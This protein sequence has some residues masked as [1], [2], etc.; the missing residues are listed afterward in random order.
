MDP[1]LIGTPEW[2][3][4][5]DVSHPESQLWLEKFCRDLRTQ[6]FYRNT[7]GPLLPNCFIESLHNW[8]QRRCE[9][10]IDLRINYTPCCEKSKFPYNAS[11]LEQCAVEA[12]A[13]LYSTPSYLWVRN[14]VSAGLK[15]LNEPSLK[16]LRV[17]NETNSIIMPT[18]KIKA[19]VVEY[20]SI[21]NYS[22]SFSNMNQFFHQVK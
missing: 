13:K 14:G 2:D 16:Q 5:F 4:S 22:L 20:D 3:K 8:M 18:P 15:F 21:Y 11:T 10:P 6:P 19:L 1:G 9:D 17:S 7:L 12:N